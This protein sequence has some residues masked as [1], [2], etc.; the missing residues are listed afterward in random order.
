MYFRSSIDV[1][2]PVCPLFQTSLQ[3]VLKCHSKQPLHTQHIILVGFFSLL[4]NSI[5]LIVP[6]KRWFPPTA[7]LTK[8]LLSLISSF[9][10]TPESIE[11]HLKNRDRI[12]HIVPFSII[13]IYNTEIY[14]HI[15][16]GVL[17]YSVQIPDCQC[18]FY[19]IVHVFVLEEN[20]I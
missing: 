8:S 18:F 12:F 20:Y 10:S 19:S 13:E 15:E 9:A 16:M 3:A 5:V 7:S 6:F 1:C 2:R 17:K 4:L 11:N 14:N